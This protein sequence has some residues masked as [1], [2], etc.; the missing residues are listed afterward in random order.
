M[1]RRGPQTSSGRGDGMK[2]DTHTHKN[3]DETTTREARAGRVQKGDAITIW[4]EYG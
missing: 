4:M 2:A 1:T 3:L